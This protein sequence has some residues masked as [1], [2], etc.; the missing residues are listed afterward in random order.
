[1]TERQKLSLN[2]PRRA[3]EEMTPKSSPVY[4]KKVWVNPTPI[5]QVKNQNPKSLLS[6]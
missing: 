5:K 6:Q 3:S 4:R 1:M 2:R